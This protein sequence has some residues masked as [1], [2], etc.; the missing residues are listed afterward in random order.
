MAYKSSKI[1]QGA[2]K[3]GSSISPILGFPLNSSSLDE[4]LKNLTTRLEAKMKTFVV[5]PNPE[6]LVFASD[7]P[8]FGK[9]LRE[10]D[11]A[12]P[13]GIGLIWASRFLGKK[14]RLNHRVSGTDLMQELCREAAIRGWSVYFLGGLPGVA[15]SAAHKLKELYPR[16]KF[17]VDEGSKLNLDQETGRLEPEKEMA[18]MV[19]NINR[20]A[21]DLL[22]V[23]FGMGK[24]EKFITDNWRNLNIG[25]AMGIGGAFDYISGKVP[26]APLFIRK[27]GFEWLFRLLRQPWRLKRQFNLL[28]FVFLV[29]KEK[30]S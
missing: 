5:T 12:V 25:L 19:E 29:F 4:V 16:L 17:F 1:S 24:Q 26:R 20:Q 2:P 10:S 7:H 8:W 9:I 14:P 6:F 28:R 22:F 15:D 18:Q 21:P 3:K 13:D 27:I 30:F 11:L 23:A